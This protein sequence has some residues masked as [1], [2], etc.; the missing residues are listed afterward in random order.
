M[1]GGDVL[2]GKECSYLCN[3]EEADSP[4]KVRL[5]SQLYK[6]IPLHDSAPIQNTL[7]D[8]A[9]ATDLLLC[10]FLH[11]RE[12]LQISKSLGSNCKAAKILIISV[13]TLMYTGSS[14]EPWSALSRDVPEAL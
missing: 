11:K 4:H 5:D 1:E 10:F 6:V 14:R 13:R 2:Q 8:A 3:A 12:S 7:E 9:L